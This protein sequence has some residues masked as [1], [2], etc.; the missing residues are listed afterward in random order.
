MRRVVTLVVLL[1]F[2]SNCA[3]RLPQYKYDLIERENPIVISERIGETV[4]VEEGE[5]V[6]LFTAIEKFTEARFFA[7]ENGGYVAEISTEGDK[8]LAV[9]RDQD[10][11]MILR[12][13]IDNYEE[14]HDDR[15][16][17]ESKWRILDYDTLGVPITKSEVDRIKKP[18]QGRACVFGIGGCILTSLAGVIYGLAW[19]ESDGEEL[20]PGVGMVAA[21]YLL[22]VVGAGLGVGVVLVL[23]TLSGASDVLKAIKK[24]RIPRRIEQ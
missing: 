15:T 18:A 17:F 24:A 5:N 20:G 3:P 10:A 4:D 11:V 6:G 13:Y 8:F 7:I 16:A 22:A 12:E 19:A 21:G 2:V 1:S 9:N 23:V 14:I